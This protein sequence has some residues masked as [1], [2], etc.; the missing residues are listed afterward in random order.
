MLIPA[1]GLDTGPWSVPAVLFVGGR[2]LSF[3]GS[4]EGIEL[5]EPLGVVSF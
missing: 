4:D 1:V 3:G 5:D 2:I